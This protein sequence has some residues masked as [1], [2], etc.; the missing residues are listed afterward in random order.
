M[1]IPARLR[2]SIATVRPDLAGLPMILHT[3]GWDSDAVE[4]GST[5]FKFPK[6]QAAVPRLRK[7]AKILA[8]VRPRV[9][10]AVPD[11]RLHERPELF[12]EHTKI[13]G[14]MI[15]TPQYDTLS[16][17]QRNAMAETL[18]GFYVALH[19]IPVDEARA[20]GAEPNPGWPPASEI[21]GLAEAAL[22]PGLHDWARTVLATYDAI[23]P[24]VTTLCY[25][26]GHGWNMAF[27][28]EHGVLNGVYDFAD[29][30]LGPRAKDLCYSSFISA[31]LTE[32]LVA[33]YDR[34]AG[35]TINPRQVALYTAIQRLAELGADASARELSWF[36]DNVV[37]WRE[38]MQGRHELRL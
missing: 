29:A 20:A 4:A 6:R 27:D 36:V 28:H 9:P 25:Y 8:L 16:E 17:T 33:A 30:G 35:V 37:Q 13:A 12:S 26:D 21:M 2:D 3:Q 38:Y 11:M 34:L 23:P 10:L 24:S 1:E 5:I 19:A 31:D 18:A 7:E 32:R 22:A 15:E 14:E